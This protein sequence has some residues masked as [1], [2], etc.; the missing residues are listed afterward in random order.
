MP[1]TGTRSSQLQQKPQ[2]NIPLTISNIYSKEK[3]KKKKRFKFG[4]HGLR[5]VPSLQ[6]PLGSSLRSQDN[7]SFSISTAI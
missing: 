7:A 4:N 3:Y 6:K 1:R 5:T 2:I